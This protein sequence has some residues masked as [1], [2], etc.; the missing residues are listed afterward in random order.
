MRI[1]T[2]AIPAWAV[3]ACVMTG[4]SA[5]DEP[6]ADQAAAPRPQVSV[7]TVQPTPRPFIRELPGRISPMRVAE[8]RAR[9][10]GIVMERL[11]NKAPK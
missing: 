6:Q 4:V 5:C 10:A 3:L 9:V 8:I 2:R 1:Q 7:V 11:F